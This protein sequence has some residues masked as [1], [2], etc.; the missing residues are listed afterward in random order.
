M[1][2]SEI[3]KSAQQQRQS[4]S[5]EKV[6]TLSVK[7]VEQFALLDLS[8]VKIVHIFLPIK[9]KKEPDTFLMIDWIKIHHPEMK[10]IVPKADFDTA[11]M[12]HHYYD[13]MEDLEMN[14]YQIL[15]PQKAEIH[16]GE[17]DMV[18]VPLLAFDKNGYRIGYGKGFYDRFLQGISTQ[19]IGL[20]LFDELN[21]ID[22][23]NEHDIRLDKCITP[24][25]TY[26][27]PIA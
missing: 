8:N 18:I 10:I 22:D 6:H 19:K 26:V 13:G 5:A 17:V 11:L 15:E 25:K 16:T 24:N 9:Q 3:R 20:S 14:H 1:N 23:I 21:V 7:L 27:F 2:K 12:T 4:L